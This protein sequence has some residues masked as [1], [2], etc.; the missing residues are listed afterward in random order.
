MKK[1]LIA[2]LFLLVNIFFW[3][4]ILATAVG[5]VFLIQTPGIMS[6]FFFIVPA[7]LSGVYVLLLKRS[8]T[9][10]RSTEYFID[11]DSLLQ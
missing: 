5:V 2:T 11:T 8:A 6:L 1:Q 7:V 4:C 9:F 3:F 10:R